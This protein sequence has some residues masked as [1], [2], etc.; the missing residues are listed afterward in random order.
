MFSQVIIIPILNILLELDRTTES[1]SKALCLPCGMCSAQA[2]SCCTC[3]MLGVK[4]FVSSFQSLPLFPPLLSFQRSSDSNRSPFRHHPLTCTCLDCV[5]Q[6]LQME[7][8]WRTSLDCPQ[9]L[10]CSDAASVPL[11]PS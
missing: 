4:L 10:V 3:F 7:G 1:N 6:E 9:A 8:L 5:L 11:Q 2:I